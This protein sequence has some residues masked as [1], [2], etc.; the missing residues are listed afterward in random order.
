MKIREG[1]ILRQ[2]SEAYVVV[3]VGEAAEIFNGMITLNE[4]GALLW[5]MLQAGCADEN[6]LVRALLAE[7]EVSEEQA[8]KDV[9][10]FVARLADAKILEA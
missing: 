6:A 7:Y 4:S 2:V 9:K 10:A 8:E 1:F 5:K 3:A